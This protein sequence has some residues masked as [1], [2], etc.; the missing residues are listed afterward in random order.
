MLKNRL[1]C[2]NICFWV[3][4]NV[5]QLKLTSKL[6]QNQFCSLNFCFCKLLPGQN[7]LLW[8]IKPTLYFLFFFLLYTLVAVRLR[9]QTN[10][11]VTWS[12]STGKANKHAAASDLFLCWTWPWKL[13]CH[14]LESAK[15]FSTPYHTSATILPSLSLWEQ[16]QPLW[17]DSSGW[18]GRVSV[19]NRCCARCQP[20]GELLIQL[21]GKP[22]KCAACRQQVWWWWRSS[23]VKGGKNNWFI[24]LPPTPECDIFILW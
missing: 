4:T 12:Y 23:C 2:L 19:S 22:A 10:K 7:Q 6:L 21:N 24:V 20:W 5:I 1:P 8:P 15:G 14:L 9:R 13:E 16:F 18:R 3:I 11:T 17:Q